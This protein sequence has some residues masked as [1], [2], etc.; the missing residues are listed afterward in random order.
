VRAISAQILQKLAQFTRH[1]RQFLA[2]VSRKKRF[3]QFFHF[4][5]AIFWGI[6]LKVDQQ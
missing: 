3:V 4:F 6:Q 1:N 5:C 2:Q